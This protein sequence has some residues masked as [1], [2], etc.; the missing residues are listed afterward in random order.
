MFWEFFTVEDQADEVTKC[1]TCLKGIHRGKVGCLP[2]NF[3]TT[4]LHKHMKSMHASQY[5]QAQ[6]KVWREEQLRKEEGADSGPSPKQRKLTAMNQMTLEESFSQ[7]KYWDINNHCSAAIHQKV[8]NTIAIDNQPFS[9]AKDQGFVELLAHFQ[10][11][12][13][14]PSRTYFSDVM[15]PNAYKEVKVC[16][17]TQLDKIHAPHIS[18]TSDM[19]TSQHSIE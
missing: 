11:K 16:L 6:E 8:M 4:P 17:L 14:L 9:I 5:K 3:S 13:M 15:L 19:W 18:F 2:K 1:K 10:P 12:Y 7:K